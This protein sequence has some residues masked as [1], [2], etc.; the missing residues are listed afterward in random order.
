MQQVSWQGIHSV[1]VTPFR[2]DG[3]IDLERFGRLLNLNIEN[4]ADGV[5]VCGST[6]EFYTMDVAERERL[7]RAAVKQADGR[8]PVIAGVADLRVETVIELC[9]IA[10]EAGCDGAL[11]L[12]PIYAMPDEREV[13]AFYRHV[14]EASPLPLMLYNSP[15]RTGVNLMPNQ[16]ERLAELP[17]VVAVKDSSAD[18]VQVTELCRRLANRIRIFVGYE[19]MIRSGL[20]VGCHGVVAMAHQLSGRLVRR[21]FDAC[22]AGDGTTADALEPALFAIYRCFRIGSYYAGIKAV[23]NELGEAVGDPRPPLLPISAEQRERVRSIL[24]DGRVAEIIR[25]F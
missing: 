16:V 17:T 5:I 6:G 25:S 2:P 23:M 8:V 24:A 22:R 19:T 20:A 3:D 12:P 1:L 7:I 13:D 9:Q 11:A 10:S 21:Y 15:R 4:G 14:S 18:I